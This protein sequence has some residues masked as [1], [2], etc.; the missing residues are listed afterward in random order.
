MGFL[1]R[2]QPPSTPAPK[3]DPTIVV[4][5]DDL[6]AC[7]SALGKMEQ[8]LLGGDDSGIRSSAREIAWAGGIRPSGDLLQWVLEIKLSD[9][10]AKPLDRPWY[11][12]VAVANEGIN[13]ADPRLAGR[14][15]FFLHGWN[16]HVAPLM[17]LADEQDCGGI[18][19][20]PRAVYAKGLGCAVR[21]LT[22]L[23]AADI[24]VQASGKAVPVGNLLPALA[25]AL[26]QLDQAGVATDPA[27][28]NAALEAVR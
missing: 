18:K 6:A 11:W 24:I 13:R 15:G 1:K 8:A 22:P 27:A 26:L 21:A 16:E 19:T 2:Q 7:A 3:P 17:G 5:D 20:I 12:L 28:R 23:D 25:G 9:P 14:I 10:D 4:G